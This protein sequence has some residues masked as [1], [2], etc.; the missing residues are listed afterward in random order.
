MSAAAKPDQSHKL[1]I[2]M[3]RKKKPQ[4]QGIGTITDNQ[5]THVL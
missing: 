3:T 2:L 1:S 5:L 4:Q